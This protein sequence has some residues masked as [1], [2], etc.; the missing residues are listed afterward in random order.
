M[1][2]V[3][4]HMAMVTRTGAN[5]KL[6][7]RNFHISNRPNNIL[8]MVHKELRTPKRTDKAGISN[9][10]TTYNTRNY[11]MLLQIQKEMIITL[12]KMK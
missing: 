7:I 9:K 10:T 2:Q 5:N 11:S 12:D 4:T 3:R 6:Q 8:H 1:G